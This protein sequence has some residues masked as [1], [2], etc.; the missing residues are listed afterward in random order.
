MTQTVQV[1]KSNEQNYL[2]LAPLDIRST[3]PDR[4][5][6]GGFDMT[7]DQLAA[8]DVALIRQVYGA[9]KRMYDLWLYM[10]GT[11]N[12]RLLREELALFAQKS[13]LREAQRIGTHTRTRSTQVAKVVHDIRGGGL[14]SL[15][16]YA[17][18]IPRM[19]GIDDEQFIRQAVF[20]ARDHAKMMRNAIPELDPIFREADE[21][22]KL[23]HIDEF[24]AK[25]RGFVFQLSDRAVA[26]TADSAFEGFITNRCLET[27]AVDR[28]LY[29]YINNA[30]R[31]AAS[32][33]VQLTI[34]PVNGGTVT[35]WVVEN[36]LYQDQYAWLKETLD[37]NLE[38][39][40]AGGYT[41][42]GSGIGLSNCS[43][44]VAASFGVEPDTAVSEKYLGAAVNG[45]TYYAWFHWPAYVPE[46]ADEPVCDCGH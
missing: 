7:L 21:G 46:S 25:W 3:R 41:R 30:A 42:G 37:L 22:M 23:H 17:Q 2:S 44:F 32:G 34:L 35:R 9:V 39:L 26:V 43:D 18:L 15:T 38:P 5:A 29:N 31:F 4:Y 45:L 10:S 13:F 1:P 6:G 8:E 16:G 40:F 20:L 33:E 14:T 28:I 36:E 27:S 24:V 11:P 12:Y 19:Q